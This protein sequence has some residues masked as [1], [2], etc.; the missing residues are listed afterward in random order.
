MEKGDTTRNTIV[1]I[2]LIIIA[3]IAGWFYYQKNK[4]VATVTET[5]DQEIF[6]FGE[7]DS[8][9][10]R[11]ENP[12]QEQTTNNETPIDQ[13]ESIEETP[14]ELPE[15]P[16]LRQIS[17]FPTGGFIGFNRIEQQEIS[18]I[19][20]DSDGN[21]LQ[22]T[23]IVDTKNQYLRYSAIKNGNI[24]ETL[25]T[26]NTLEQDLV[27][28]NFIPNAE[29]AY[30]A[31]GGESVIFQYWNKQ[32]NL[33]ESYLAKIES[34]QLDVQNC[35]FEFSSVVE[36]DVGENIIDLHEFLNRSPQTQVA[37][38]G[39][40]SPGNEGS[41]V[42]TQTI[43]AIKNFQSVYQIDIDGQIGPGTKSKMQ[44]VCNEQQRSIALREFNETE[45][46]YVTTGFFLP[47]NII[48]IASN[49]LKPEFFYLQKDNAGTVGVLQNMETE[50][51]RTLFES[52]FSEWTSH[53]NSRESIEIATKPSYASDGYSYQLNSLDGRYFKS[54]PSKKGL[55]TKASPDNSKI[56]ISHIVNERL[57]LAIHDRNNNRTIPL[58]LQTFSDKCSWSIDSSNIYCSVPNALAYGEEYPDTWYQGLET[59]TDS[60]WKINANNQE[61]ELLEDILTES[62]VLIDVSEIQ[63]DPQDEY[64]YFLDK[65]TEFLWSYRL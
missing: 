18:D 1:I 40:N 65:N 15:G 17:D 30:F 33:A 6:P 9:G 7:F 63:T 50:E 61:E 60:L 14:E 64:I 34:I 42:T 12:E 51:T 32:E 49:P 37:R 27:V 5:E 26:P 19:E 62:G 2:M 55:T 43:T 22:T 35:P 28:E 11:P 25:I 59:Y 21:T 47:Q 52:P 4:P 31:Q 29:K 8:N 16:R 36:G 23:R 13:Q 39:A 10:S 56:L 45:E 46:K 20:I 48:S 24:Y 44:E 41:V 3:A 54:L 58:N 57:Q 53:W 38:T